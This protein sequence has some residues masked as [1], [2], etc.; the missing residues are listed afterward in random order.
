MPLNRFGTVPGL[1]AR[2]KAIRDNSEK[3]TQQ[4]FAKYIAKIGSLDSVPTNGTMSKWEKDTNE[5]SCRVLLAYAEAAGCTVDELLGKPAPASQQ[6]VRS[7]GALAV[8]S[9][10]VHDINMSSK[11]QTA[12]IARLHSMLSEKDKIIANLSDALARLGK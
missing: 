3:R 1:G 9:S 10:R 5:P 12:E 2:L 7:P 4:T 11:E 6:L 8:Q